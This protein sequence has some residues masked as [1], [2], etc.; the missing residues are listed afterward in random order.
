[1]DIPGRALERHAALAATATH[2]RDLR[3]EVAD[4]AHARVPTTW[5]VLGD[6]LQA[7]AGGKAYPFGHA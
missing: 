1:M 3:H 6:A 4:V 2:P 7:V 5:A